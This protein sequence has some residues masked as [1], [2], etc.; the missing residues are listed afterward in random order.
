[1]LVF[2]LTM[3]C[4]IVA[5][6]ILFFVV[7]FTE[8]AFF[9]IQDVVSDLTQLINRRHRDGRLVY[10]KTLEEEQL[11]RA[12]TA[13]ESYALEFIADPKTLERIRKETSSEMVRREI[14]NKLGHEWVLTQTEFHQCSMGNARASGQYLDSCYGV[15]CQ[16]CDA[17]NRTEYIYSC[18][19]C[20]MTTVTFT[21]HSQE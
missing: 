1:M 21:P 13:G 8:K 2:F 15:D 17:H 4:I 18:P 16:F 3:G 14:C 12:A 20:G 7:Y 9:A 10:L 11:I 19:I 6:L 5:P